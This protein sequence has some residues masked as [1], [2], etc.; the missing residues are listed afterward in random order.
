MTRY[1]VMY[2]SN[3]FT[4]EVAR[5]GFEYRNDALTFAKDL[6]NKGVEVIRIV[7]LEPTQMP[8]ER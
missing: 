1:I 2:T 5:R 7:N 8:R 3:M 6:R 4:R